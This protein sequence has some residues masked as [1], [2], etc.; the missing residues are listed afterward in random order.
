MLNLRPVGGLVLA[1]LDFADVVY[2]KFGDIRDARQAYD[3]VQQAS[4]GWNISYIE[5]KLF[6]AKNSTT[7]LPVSNFEGQILV[8]VT[9]SVLPHILDNINLRKALKEILQEFGEVMA[10]EPENDDGM[11]IFYRAEYFDTLPVKDA[12]S[13]LNNRS[14][15]VSYR[16]EH[17]VLA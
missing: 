12:L 3:S 7:D 13:L 15:G 14:I 11:A 16:S 8:K 10:L 5:P 6:A 4:E 9:P 17:R 2:A 1:D